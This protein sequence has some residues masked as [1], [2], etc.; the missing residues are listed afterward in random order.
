M[1]VIDY[2]AGN[3]RALAYPT[4]YDTR[5]QAEKKIESFRSQGFDALADSVH[6]VE[7]D[8]EVKVTY[9]KQ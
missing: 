9:P 4:L 5:E 8:G 7:T 3:G 2:K 1:F 6:V